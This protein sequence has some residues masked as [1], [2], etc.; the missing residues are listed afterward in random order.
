MPGR[1]NQYKIKIMRNVFKIFLILN[2][3]AVAGCN[4]SGGDDNGP[5]GPD[6][7][8]IS[9][10]D[11]FTYTYYDEAFRNPERGWY[12]YNAFNF[13]YGGG[14]ATPAIA[15]NTVSNH[16]KNGTTII[17]TIYHMFD[18]VDKPLSQTFLD[19]FEANMDAIREGGA[20]CLLRF[21]YSNSYDTANDKPK[22]NSDAPFDIFSGHIAQL[23]PL[24]QKHGDVLYAM[25]AGFVG[26]W[27]EWYYTSNY[28]YR[29]ST[30]EDYKPRKQLVDKLLDAVPKDRM[31]CLRYPVAKLRMYEIEYAD[32]VTLATAYNQSDLSRLAMHN[33]CFLASAN[34]VGT[35]A[36]GAQRDFWHK[37]SRY[38]IMGGETCGTSKYS[39]CDNTITQ[40]ENF[41]YSY[42]NSNY[43]MS[44]ISGW[45]NEGCYDEVNKRL[46]YRLAL[47]EAYFTEKPSA[48]KPLEIIL[49]IENKGFAAPMNPRDME[50]VFVEKGGSGNPVRIKTDVDPRYWFAGLTHEVKL[51]L[52]ISALTSGKTYEV[53][54]NLP[55]PKP[56]INTRP[57]YSIR[58]ANTNVWDE[59]TGYNKLGEITL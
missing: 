1:N 24:L 55:D 13:P 44:V 50:I 19:T 46:G 58:L 21:A 6:G 11:K 14:T 59:N 5:D 45:R 7:P 20:K 27:G 48:D 49:H 16:V 8:D 28:N 3:F 10:F 57:E 40:M 47:T 38:M 36:N 30:V 31:I 15:V 25:E 53:S 26:A 23:K 43:H 17:H 18:F 34:D 32:S 2:M 35:F 29:P 56:A 42:L 9:G 52:D 51:S 33:D 12:V 4:S 54:L 37:E 41:H 39:V 22:D